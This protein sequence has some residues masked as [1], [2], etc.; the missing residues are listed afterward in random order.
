M[1]RV[2]KLI[3]SHPSSFQGGIFMDTMCSLNTL[4]IFKCFFEKEND[5]HPV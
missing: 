4:R 1:G 2:I 3:C 5:Y